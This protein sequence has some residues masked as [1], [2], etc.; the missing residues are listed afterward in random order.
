MKALFFISLALNILLIAFFI[1]KR[2][3]F[4]KSGKVDWAAMADKNN[5]EKTKQFASFTITSK[6]IVFI[7]TSRTEGFPVGEFFDNSKNRGIGGN[8]LKHLIGRIDQVIAGKPRKLFI[9]IGINDLN[10]GVSMSNIKTTYCNLLD[11]ISKGAPDTHVYIQSVLPRSREFAEINNKV[12]ELNKFLS[13]IKQGNLTYVDMYGTFTVDGY[14]NESL[15]TDGLHLNLAGYLLWRDA[16]K[17][18][19]I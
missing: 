2:I 1:F 13:S 18:Y 19:V 12:V 15:S 16:I 9:E 17:E 4:A 10:E 3:Y 8:M 14:M 11:K 6:D 5:A 7:G